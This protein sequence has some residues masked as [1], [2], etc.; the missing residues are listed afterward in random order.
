MTK[1]FVHDRNKIISMEGFAASMQ[2]QLGL[3]DHGDQGPTTA[4]PTEGIPRCDSSS[5]VGPDVI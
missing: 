1:V 2:W 3:Y 4:R 5:S